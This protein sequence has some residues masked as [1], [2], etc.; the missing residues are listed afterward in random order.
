MRKLQERLGTIILQE[1]DYRRIR[2]LIGDKPKFA[3]V[4]MEISMGHPNGKT[5]SF[6]SK[7]KDNELSGLDREIN[8]KDKAVDKAVRVVRFPRY[9]A[10]N[11]R[12]YKGYSPRQH[13]HI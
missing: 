7:W 10:E 8:L 5:G 12:E 2:R 6:P 13:N 4:E 9:R 3:H 11:K 1:R